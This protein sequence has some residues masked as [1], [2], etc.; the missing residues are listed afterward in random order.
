MELVV[1]TPYGEVFRGDV[2]SVVLPGAEG[3]FGVLE[4]HE[5]FLAPLRVGLL[6]LEAQEGPLYGAISGGF[7]DVSG[8][9]VIVLAES[10]EAAEDIDVARAE[11]AAD[12]AREALAAPDADEKRE[13][14][15]Q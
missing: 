12:R 2:K 4:H 11:L 5:R 8:H 1:V 3:D 6:E 9:L 14:Y 10:A 13:R 15:V 7:A